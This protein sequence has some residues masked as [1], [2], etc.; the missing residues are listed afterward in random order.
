MRPHVEALRKGGYRRPL[1][2]S[3]HTKGVQ[4]H[5]GGHGDPLED[6]AVQ[7]S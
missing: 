2:R 6:M 3:D 4:D 5:G 7:G 1:G